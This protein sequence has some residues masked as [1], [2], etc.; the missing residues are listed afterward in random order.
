[1]S[2]QE[3]SYE[4]LF[5]HLYHL[6]RIAEVTR[7]SNQL[8]AR[9]AV[10]QSTDVL[11]HLARSHGGSL[12]LLLTPSG[13]YLQERLLRT[14]HHIADMADAI[15][16]ELNTLGLHEITLTSGLRPDDLLAFIS[17]AAKLAAEPL[18]R[19]Q[20]LELSPRLTLAHLDA[21][22]PHELTSLDADAPVEDRIVHVCAAAM[23][24]V[25]Q[26]HDGLRSGRD[27]A[28][29]SVKRHI[30]LLLDLTLEAP[31]LVLSFVTSIQRADPSALA[32]KGA[33]LATLTARHLFDDRLHL[34]DVALAAALLDAGLIRACG[35]MDHAHK[36]GLEFA[37]RPSE[38]ALDRMPEAAA[39][40]I[41][42]WSN[43]RSLPRALFAYEA[44][45]LLRRASRGMPYDGQFPPTLEAIILAIVRR[46]LELT[47][48]DLNAGPRRPPEDAIQILWRESSTRLERSLVQLFL[49]AI[50]FTMRGT[51]VQLTSG[52]R[53]VVVGN[54]QRDRALS[55]PVV[56]LAYDPHGRP[57]PSPIDVDLSELRE[58][59]LRFGTIR[60]V[61]RGNDE[62]L[63]ELHE[64]ITR[65]PGYTP[66]AHTPM[67]GVPLLKRDTPNRRSLP[68]NQLPPS[69]D[70]L[71]AQQPSPDD[72]L[73]RSQS[74]AF[75]DNFRIT[76]GG[77]TRTDA[78]QV[79]SQSVLGD[80]SGSGFPSEHD[81]YD[82][83]FT[84]SDS[85]TLDDEKT[86]GT[87]R[88]EHTSM[89]DRTGPSDR[90]SESYHETSQR[91]MISDIPPEM[92]V[93]LITGI[94]DLNQLNPAWQDAAA[95]EGHTAR[96]QPLEAATHPEEQLS[97]ELPDD[98][99][100]TKIITIPLAP[101]TPPPDLEPIYHD[102]KTHIIDLNADDPNDSTNVLP[103][104]ILS[105][106]QFD[107]K[108]K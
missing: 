42:L 58:D 73:E 13:P 69:L 74:V 24:A 2:A 23:I 1:M 102:E 52:A 63:F 43:M 107:D 83:L 22:L 86:E 51:P 56:R 7:T 65:Q 90:F 30:Q 75:S 3:T 98:A 38:D 29:R 33:I 106:I 85:G 88:L 72:S 82:D 21:Q 57:L 66:P 47:A 12:R 80:L 11:E 96:T 100:A 108:K 10:L 60:G 49:H 36:R 64:Q 54:L 67:F 8:P 104:A 89:T 101:P 19:P 77:M 39:T 76:S 61:V 79:L 45:A 18:T 68:A 95:R 97:T 26:L 94:Y 62:R 9:R 25:E 6:L 48:I 92:M 16:Q 105:H 28:I 93:P 4:P 14:P 44:H 81:D 31:Q 71:A 53:G 35:L 91:V 103:T 41:A 17:T 99:E 37:P 59:S 5:Q 50:G 70:D 32:I 46:Y 40:M 55:F 27:L 87:S 84:S 78:V 15:T 20:R 34:R